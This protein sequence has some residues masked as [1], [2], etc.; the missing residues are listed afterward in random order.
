VAQEEVK[1]PADVTRKIDEAR[2]A[3]RKSVLMPID[4]GGDLRFVAVRIDHG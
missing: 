4:R 1:G 3:G 2:S